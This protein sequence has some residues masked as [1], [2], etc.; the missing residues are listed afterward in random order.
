[1]RQWF[2]ATWDSLA[3]MLLRCPTA[4]VPAPTMP[5]G[6]LAWSAQVSSSGQECGARTCML[7]AHPHVA[8]RALHAAVDVHT[9]FPS[10][11]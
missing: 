2:A 9:C 1:M 7:T 4:T 10:V 11:N 5:L 3:G 8:L 6:Q